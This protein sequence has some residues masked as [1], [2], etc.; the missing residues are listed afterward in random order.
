MFIARV[1]L[2]FAVAMATNARSFIQSY[3]DRFAMITTRT[4]ERNGGRIILIIFFS[5]YTDRACFGSVGLGSVVPVL[6]LSE[7]VYVAWSVVERISIDNV[8]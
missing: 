2:S 4:N 8:S 7:R 3:T 5:N 1:V 6:L